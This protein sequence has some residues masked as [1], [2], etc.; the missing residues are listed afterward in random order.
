MMFVVALVCVDDA[1][2]QVFDDVDAKVCVVDDDDKEDVMTNIGC[3]DVGKMPRDVS[4]V[5]LI[6]VHHLCDDL[7]PLDVGV[8]LE[9]D[10]TDEVVQSYLLLSDENSVSDGADVDVDVIF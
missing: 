2:E 6:N 9:V 1:A 10:P 4:K 7:P 8:L 3:A 5:F